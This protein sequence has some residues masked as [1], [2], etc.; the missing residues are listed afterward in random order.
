M[1]ICGLPLGIYSRKAVSGE[2][3]LRRLSLQGCQ[4]MSTGKQLTDVSDFNAV[5]IDVA[6]SSETLVLLVKLRGFIS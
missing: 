2:T 4:T 1:Y 6:T 3:Y 5:K